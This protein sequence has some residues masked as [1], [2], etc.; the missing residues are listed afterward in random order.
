MITKKEYI[1]IIVSIALFSILLAYNKEIFS[2]EK[3]PIYLLISAII[4]LTSIFAKKITAKKIHV[5]IEH[6][7]WEFERYGIAK[8]NHLRY[9]ILIG[10]FLPALLSFLSGGFIKF[11]TF[12]EFTSK[13]LPAKS[14]KRFGI[15][16]FSTMLEW[17][18]GRIG[19]F[20]L[21]AVMA[22]AIIAKFLIS[23]S[24]LPFFELAKYSLYYA[25]YNAIPFSTLDGMKIFMGSRPLYIFALILLIATGLIVFL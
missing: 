6:K 24:S 5:E 2:L 11:L 13:E 17:D 4:I 3:I 18:D 16:R 14:T 7:I 23:Y 9:P 22:L 19:F 10:F 1:P 12:M 15:K 25:A 21:V 20:G 8:G